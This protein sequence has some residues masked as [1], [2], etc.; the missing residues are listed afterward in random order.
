MEFVQA[1]FRDMT[2]PKGL[3]LANWDKAIYDQISGFLQS[4]FGIPRNW[5][6]DL[7][8]YDVNRRRTSFLSGERVASRFSC[9]HSPRISGVSTPRTLSPPVQSGSGGTA[10]SSILKKDN[11]TDKLRINFTF[12][13]EKDNSTVDLRV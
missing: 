5:F 7:S 10:A 8:T 9:S 6:S 1:M 11:L 4:N 3:P 2:T 13:E 12:S